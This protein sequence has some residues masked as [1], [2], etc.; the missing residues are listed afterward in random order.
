MRLLL[1]T[2]TY[3]WWLL[4]HPTLSDDARTTIADGENLVFVSAATIWEA[5]I[6]SAL[7]RLD[8]HDAD[9][10]EEI[11]SNG[12]HELPVEARHA[13]TT[14]SLQA[15]HK[16]PFDRMLV[17]QAQLEQLTIVTRDTAFEPYGV[18]TLPA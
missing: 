9:L 16:D 5:T 10:V 3:L 8:I 13:A 12:F 18:A 7:G 6:K 11:G 15:H 2:H 14:G 1:D 17:A 4:D